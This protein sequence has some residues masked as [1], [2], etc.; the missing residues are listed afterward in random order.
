MADPGGLAEVVALAQAA[1]DRARCAAGLCTGCSGRYR[2]A[3]Q[4]AGLYRVELA[5]CPKGHQQRREAL[6]GVSGVPRDLPV[7]AFDPPEWWE[8]L[9]ADPKSIPFIFQ[10]HETPHAVPSAGLQAMVVGWITSRDEEARYVSCPAL[11]SVPVDVD[12][13]EVY[14][15]LT[16]CGL[17]VLDGYGH[18]LPEGWRLADLGAVVEWRYKVRQPTVVNLA[19]KAYGSTGLLRSRC[20]EDLGNLTR[21]LEWSTRR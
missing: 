20:A 4:Y 10:E 14:D 8:V 9:R 1:E 6:L 21:W 2:V 17:L 7:P 12:W 11:W 15:S 3:V 13:A 5:S 19:A 18:G 16:G